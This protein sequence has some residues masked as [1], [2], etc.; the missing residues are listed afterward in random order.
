MPLYLAD[1][2]IKKLMTMRKMIFF[3]LMI[4]CSGQAFSQS[5][6]VRVTVTGIKNTTGK[7]EIGLYND[8]A[9]F[10]DYFEVFKGASLSPDTNGITYT[11]KELPEGRYA[12]AA[13]QDKNNDKKLNKNLFG[14]PTERYGFSLNKFGIFGP[15]DFDDISFIV[16]N[17]KE[18][19]LSINLE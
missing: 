1:R 6:T 15:P 8:K 7:V 9:T 3:C 16:E 17:G 18:L 10:P 13:W 19:V 4:A 2:L 5:G 11:F 14:S 12:I